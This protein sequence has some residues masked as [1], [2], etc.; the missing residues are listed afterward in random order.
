M[1]P[2][3]LRVELLRELLPDGWEIV[4]AGDTTEAPMDEAQAAAWLH[5]SVHVLRR[6]RTTGTG[7]AYRKVGR[8]P[9]Y[10]PEDLREWVQGIKPRKSPAA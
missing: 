9:V 1:L 4:Q 5:T 3:T 8:N 6:H 7:P 2:P 10:L